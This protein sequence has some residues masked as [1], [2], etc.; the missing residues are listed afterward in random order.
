MLLSLRTSSARSIVAGLAL[1]AATPSTLVAQFPVADFEA[2]V[3]KGMKEWEV[4]GVA[5]GIVHNDSI[6]LLKGY[7]VRT[8]GKPDPVDENTL[9]AI[10]SDTKSFTGILLAMLA[11]DGKLKWDD[12]VADI[13]P[14]FQLADPLA[15][16]DLTVRDLITHR[17]GLARGDLLWTGGWPYDTEELIR[18][19]R[20]LKPTWSLR[21]HY[22]YNNLM[23]TAAGQVA[24]TAAHKPWTQ[25]L[26]ERILDPLGMTSTNTSVTLLPSL[27]NV[28]S[29]HGKVDDTIRVVSFTNADQIPA[30]G[31]INSNVADMVKWLRFQLDS[32]RVTGKRL[33]S[34]PNFRETHTPQTVVPIDSAYR[35]MN[36]F[37]HLQSYAFG[38][39]VSDFRGREMLRHSGNLSGMAAQVGLLP[40]ERFG[41]VVLSNLGGNALRES[42]MYKAFDLIL[43]APPKDWSAENLAEARG[44]RAR[45]RTREAKRDS[46]RVHGTHPSL[47]LE[48]Y[49]GDYTD[50]FYGAAKVV[51]EN[52]HLVFNFG[53]S[54]LGDM[55]HWHYDTFRIV[56]RD[57]REGKAFAT[58]QLDPAG[59]VSALRF[60]PDGD[61]VEETPVF[62]RQ[63]G[64]LNRLPPVTAR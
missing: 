18:R 59:K 42:L 64:G 19:L 13:L 44:L 38:W 52:G 58:F 57:H 14:G 41:I 10:A 26:K 43:G 40:E 21:S 49:T 53:R 6:I 37:T 28:A 30:A 29:P 61:F 46:A 50:P 60:D 22:G 11:D 4:P 23:Y 35:A 25:L 32:G 56:W 15:T 47:A 16:R 2:Y 27:P 63:P 24:A 7:G 8:I 5:I 17:S 9:F 54:F 55:E 51:V 12:K 34:A 39:T 36:P 1:Y 48:N 33:V 62:T 20:Y 31:A 3:A 45:A